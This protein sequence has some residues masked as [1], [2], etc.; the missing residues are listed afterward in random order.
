MSKLN[1]LVLNYYRWL[2]VQLLVVVGITVALSL[3]KHF[4]D[5]PSDENEWHWAEWLLHIA[6]AILVITVL[7]FRIDINEVKSLYHSTNGINQI[8]NLL[9]KEGNDVQSRIIRPL[10]EKMAKDPDG[11]GTLLININ[12]PWVLQLISNFCTLEIGYRQE[13]LQGYLEAATKT[14]FLDSDSQ[15]LDNLEGEIRQ[16]KKIK[17]YCDQSTP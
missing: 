11:Y 2:Q 5:W 16:F 14:N 10:I 8:L 12:N 3:M 15:E 6:T 17:E 13:K 9:Q 1:I 7:F 4:F